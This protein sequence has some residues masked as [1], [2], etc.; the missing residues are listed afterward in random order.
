[1]TPRKVRGR[2][3]LRYCGRGSRARCRA[4]LFGAL[5]AAAAELSS[6]QG[7]DPSKWRSDAT[8][9]RIKFKPGLLPNSMRWVNRPTFQQV[10]SF[11]KTP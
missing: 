11:G 9:E 10:I 8:L 4:A 2:F 7:A 1:M 3:H 6:Q 5:R